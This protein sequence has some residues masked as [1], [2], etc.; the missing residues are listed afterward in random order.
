[1]KE[2][3]N[4]TTEHNKTQDYYIATACYQSKGQLFHIKIPFG[5]KEIQNREDVIIIHK[6][7][8]KIIGKYSIQN[9]LERV[10]DI[11][12]FLKSDSENFLC[13]PKIN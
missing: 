1:M 3:K 9:N 12:V 2:E 6:E 13:L 8:N 7:A 11:Q 5:S 10:F 4:K